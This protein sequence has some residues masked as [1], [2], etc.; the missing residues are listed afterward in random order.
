MRYLARR[1][2]RAIWLLVGVSLLSFVLLELAPG[3][4]FVEMK[5]DPDISSRTVA[6][7]RHE[8][9][10]DRPLH[11][12]YVRWLALVARGDFGYSFAYNAPVS[13]LIWTRA[14]NT[15]ILTVPATVLA[16]TIAVA[17]GVWT[18]T[19]PGRWLDRLSGLASSTLLTVPDL[20]IALLLLMLALQTGWFPTGGMASP[21]GQASFAADAA[22][23]ARHAAL[24]VVA[25]V[26]GI[27]PTL[28][29]H[30]RASMIEALNAPAVQAARGHGISRRRLLFRYALP[31]AANPLLSLAGFS[32]GSLLSASLLVEAIMGWPGLGPLLLEAVL[33]R[34]VFIVIGAIVLS[35]AFLAA[36]NL[37]ADVCLLVVDP[38]I[39]A[40]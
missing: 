40:A 7:L 37:A 12:R 32:L 25:L 24:P 18:A 8:H 39:R 27:V 15:L 21:G 2:L 30:V 31:L 5:L 4:F 28:F 10:L 16:W 23:V 22:D 19:R 3:D 11:V 9:G 36:G 6:A 33:A 26:L 13:S 17:L 14:L 1:A 35:T 20:L 34:D 29:R 38:R